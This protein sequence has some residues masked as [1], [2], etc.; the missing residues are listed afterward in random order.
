V[1][2]ETTDIRLPVLS[3]QEAA[4][5]RDGQ[6]AHPKGPTTPLELEHELMQLIQAHI[7]CG[8]KW[9]HAC[10]LK[11]KICEVVLAKRGVHIFGLSAHARTH[12]NP[13]H[14]LLCLLGL[15]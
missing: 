14:R 10:A 2:L 4:S 5:A 11:S 13:Q 12:F 7:N 15:Y 1:S 9:M 6:Q 3:V 8:L